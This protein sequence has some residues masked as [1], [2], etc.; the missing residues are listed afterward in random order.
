[1]RPQ[2]SELMKDREFNDDLNETERNARLSFKRICKDFLWNHNAA[3]YQDV[4]Q[5]LLTLY[6]AM[7][8]NMSLKIRFLEFFFFLRKS[9]RSQWRARCNISPRHFGYGKAVQR[10]VDLKYVGRLLLGTEEGRTWS[11]LPAKIIGLYILEI[12][13]CLVH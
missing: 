3:N 4:V 5:D 8:C 13:F 6:K 2:I 11:Q 9:L 1:M 12:N 10:Q 7:G